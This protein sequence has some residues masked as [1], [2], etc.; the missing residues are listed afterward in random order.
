MYE[1]D[2]MLETLVPGSKKDRRREILDQLQ[3]LEIDD[4]DYVPSGDDDFTIPPPK[5]SNN[6]YDTSILPSKFLTKKT[7]KLE[8]KRAFTTQTE[9]ED[10]WIRALMDSSDVKIKKGKHGSNI[11]DEDG[12]KKKKKKKDK[13][14]N[15]LTDYKKEFETESALLKNL[16][17][18]QAHFV[19]SLQKEYDFLK[20]NK[21]S[22][23]GMNKNTTDLIANIT[24]SRALITQL[25]DKQISLKK[26]IADLSMKEKKEL[27]GNNLMEGENL[28]DFASSYMKKLLEEKR[29]NFTG[30]NDAIGEYNFDEMSDILHEN[31]NENGGYEDRPEEVEKYLE[32]EDRNVT[33]YALVDSNDAE[34]YEFVAIDDEGNEIGDYPLPF[35]NTLS[36]NRSTDIA[37]DKFGQKYPI[38]WR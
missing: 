6:N 2:T 25:V 32:Y 21:S 22:S 27:A 34:N 11:F 19:D 33:I 7:K 30:G 36:I 13:D 29:Q 3:Q 37:T 8:R 5:P 17:I 18:D 28:A 14:K 31:L 10:D 16:M 15:E 24:S 23:R 12:G 9:E 26:T 35:K 20:S 1:N 38:R 4:G